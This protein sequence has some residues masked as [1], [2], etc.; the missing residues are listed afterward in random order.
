MRRI[1]LR[2]ILL[3]LVSS[4]RLFAQQPSNDFF[5]LSV[6]NRWTYHY[7]ARYDEQL[8]QWVEIDTGT[9]RYTIISKSPTNDSTIWVF[10]EVRNVIHQYFPFGGGGWSD[11]VNDSTTFQ[12]VEYQSENHKVVSYASNWKSVFYFN[13]GLT[14]FSDS[15][16]FLRY[17]PSQSAD[18]FTVAHKQYL[19]T[20]LMNV[21]TVTYQRLLGLT[22][23]SLRTPGVTGFAHSTNHTLISAVLTSAANGK[24]EFVPNNFALE[25]NFPNPFNPTTTILFH[26]P[27]DT[28]VAI[29]I[30]DLLGRLVVTLCDDNIAAGFH[31]LV[32]NASNQST[33]TYFCV[34]QVN[35]QSQFIRLT[36]AK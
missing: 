15:V 6:G 21:F 7:F 28:R 12:L 10:K 4:I 5:P 27:K 18:T 36:L 11:A 3:S 35:G 23:V 20:R 31:S 33:G 8:G 19:L 14:N 26:T 30:Y 22:K 25:Q 17:F 32:W 1:I 13:Y 2:L 9:T 16:S 29:R 24:P 34:A